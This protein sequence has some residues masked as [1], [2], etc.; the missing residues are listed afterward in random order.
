MRFGKTWIGAAIVAS[1]V[2][3]AC[4]GTGRDSSSR[5]HPDGATLS[6]RDTNRVLGPGDVRVMNTDS[7]V[8]IAVIGDSV[9]TGFGPRVRA[10]LEESTGSS[11]ESGS[12]FSASIEKIV[13]KAVSGAFNKE[14][15]YPIAEIQDVRLEDGKL[16]F[17]RNDGSRMK[18]LDSNHSN[19]RPIAETFAVSEAERFIAAFH[20]RKSKGA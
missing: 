11:S 14:L 5:D 16:E 10:E 4:G 18:I 20:A 15:K 7:S 19:N 8:E 12:G 3:V 2:I 17:Y 1:L 6:T 9:V 13:K